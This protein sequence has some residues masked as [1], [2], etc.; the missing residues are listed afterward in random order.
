M[1][2]AMASSFCSLVRSIHRFLEQYR[3]ADEIAKDEFASPSSCGTRR[4]LNAMG[5]N[6]PWL[7]EVAP[8]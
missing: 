1:I 6:H 4:R 8:K 5:F 3:L 7:G 2:L